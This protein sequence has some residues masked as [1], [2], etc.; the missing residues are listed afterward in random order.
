MARIVDRHYLVDFLNQC[1]VEQEGNCSFCIKGGFHICQ[2]SL[3]V[4]SELRLKLI[5]FERAST[6]LWAIKYSKRHPGNFIIEPVL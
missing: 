3:L 1:Y 4:E 2:R 6:L 5:N